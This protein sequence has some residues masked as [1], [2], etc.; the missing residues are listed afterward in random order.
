MSTPRTGTPRIRIDVITGDLLTQH[1]AD[2][3]VNPWNRNFVPRWLLLRHGVS[4]ALKNLTGPAPWRTLHACGLLNV[5]EAVVTDGGHLSQTLIHV[6]GLHATWRA[7]EHSVRTSVRNAAETAWHRGHHTLAMPLIGA[8]TGGLTPGQV[9]TWMT[10]AL[11]PWTPDDTVSDA[12]VLTVRIV[13]Y[14]P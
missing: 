2:A 12:D 3:W 9:L 4:G 1:D 14:Q 8:G 13:R 11:S 7:S 5:G 6:A 10:D